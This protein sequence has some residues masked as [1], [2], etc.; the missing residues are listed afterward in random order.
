[1]QTKA[2]SAKTEPAVARSR[3]AVTMSVIGILLLLLGRRRTWSYR[4]SG[5]SQSFRRRNSPSG[6][7][8]RETGHTERT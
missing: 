2:L 4:E 8:K 1:M 3:Q 7:P 6:R 5:A